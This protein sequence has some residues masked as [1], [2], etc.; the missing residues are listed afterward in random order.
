ME[1]IASV[2][3]GGLLPSVAHEG[4]VEIFIDLVEPRLH[5]EGHV[6]WL[7]EHAAPDSAHAYFG[8]RHAEFLWQA[9]RLTASMLENLCRSGV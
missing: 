5:V 7:Q 6:D 2:R 9:H 1:E 8:A 4:L 3:R